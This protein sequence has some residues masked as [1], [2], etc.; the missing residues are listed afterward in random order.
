MTQP[1]SRI[2]AA[3]I[4]GILRQALIDHVLQLRAR[5]QAE[6]TAGGGDMAATTRKHRAALALLDS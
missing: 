2:L 4:H 6:D 5:V 3:A 1:R